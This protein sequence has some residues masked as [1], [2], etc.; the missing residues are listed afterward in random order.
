MASR[1]AWCTRSCGESMALFD[2]IHGK[3]VFGRRVRKLAEH[4]AAVLPENAQVL[5]VGCGDGNVA[6][7]IMQRRPD[8][9]IK[10]LDVLVRPMTHIPVEKFDGKSLPSPDASYDAVM[11]VDV[12]HHTEDP[13]VLLREADRVARKAVVLKDHTCDG[14]LAR[15][16]LRFMDHVGNARHGVVLPYNYWSKERWL[17]AFGELKWKIV[18][19]QAKLGLYPW[20]ASWIFG[21]SL[22]FVARLERST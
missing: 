8:V 15:P 22:H 9:S 20:P 12:L 1:R 11:F 2:H 17:A 14:L 19:W 16:T 6:W 18:A 13:M 5:D 10:G 3:F 4:L 7:L 21:R